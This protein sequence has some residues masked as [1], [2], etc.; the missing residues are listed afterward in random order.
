MATLNITDFKAKLAGGG[1][2]SNLFEVEMTPPDGT[3]STINVAG[4]NNDPFKFLCKAAALP[5]SNIGSVDLNIRGRV[6]HVYGDR[7]FDPWTITVIND[8]DFKYRKLFE[9]WID[10]I[11]QAKTQA[12]DPDPNH[13][14]GSAK[15]I[16]LKRDAAGS[17]AA[18]TYDMKLIYPTNISAI[19]LSYDSSDTIEEFTVEFQVHD[20]AAS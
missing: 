16:Q 5:A 11:N 1:A 12:G 3:A 8:I 20:F 2:R 19:D 15:V 6:F 14:M 13:Y 7:T 10:L 9:S 17:K 4:W 18:R